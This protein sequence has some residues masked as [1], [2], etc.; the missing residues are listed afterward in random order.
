MI[1]TLSKLKRA[2][3]ERFARARSV[4]QAVPIA[5]VLE[6]GIFRVGRD[7]YAKTYRDLCQDF[8]H[9]N[10]RFHAAIAIALS[11]GFVRSKNASI[12]SAGIL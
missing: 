3:R 9:G 11:I 10:S 8:G 5:Q 7:K 12:T 6:D 4:E 2:E 1:K